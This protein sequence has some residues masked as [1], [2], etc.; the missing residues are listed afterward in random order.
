[1]KPIA[2]ISALIVAFGLMA[3]HS[4]KKDFQSE[5]IGNASPESIDHGG[6][7]G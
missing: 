5:Q 2:K 7:I 3:T 6:A 1:M 4:C